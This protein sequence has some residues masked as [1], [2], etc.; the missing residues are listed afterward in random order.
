MNHLKEKRRKKK[1]LSATLTE[2]KGKVIGHLP[3][4]VSLQIL[5]V[6]VII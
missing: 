1:H 2:V 6:H 5:T 4:L 3:K